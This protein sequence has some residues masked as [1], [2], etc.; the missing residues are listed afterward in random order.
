[1]N[2]PKPSFLGR[3]A[4]AQVEPETAPAPTMML[5]ADTANGDLRAGIARLSERTHLMG[6]QIVE[7]KQAVDRLQRSVSQIVVHQSA[8]ASSDN[9][10]HTLVEEIRR[11][12]EQ[13]RAAITGLQ[14]WQFGVRTATV[15]VASMA[16][17]GGALVAWCIEHVAFK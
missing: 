12:R 17:G 14:K 9:Q 2:D 13:D 4:L 1:M 16:A 11:E 10:L 3:V 5:D 15:T 7:I 8:N 6:A